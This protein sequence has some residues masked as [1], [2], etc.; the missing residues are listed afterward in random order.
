MDMCNLGCASSSKM[1]GEM[2]AMSCDNRKEELHRVY[3]E[4]CWLLVMWN[5]NEVFPII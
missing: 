3:S 2:K 5:G 1:C 4:G